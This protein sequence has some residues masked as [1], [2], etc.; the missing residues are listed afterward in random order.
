MKSR[1]LAL[2]VS[3]VLL[4]GI[5]AGCAGPAPTGSEPAADATEEPAAEAP[6]APMSVAA[7]NCDYGG[8]IESIEAVDE[9]TVQFNL[10]KPDPAFLAK[11]AFTPFGIQPAEYI[12]ATGGT[13]AILETAHRHRPLQG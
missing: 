5:L 3:A 7:E 8:K 4:L 6:F 11:V 13:G 2:I 12:A 10:C 1:S 9:M